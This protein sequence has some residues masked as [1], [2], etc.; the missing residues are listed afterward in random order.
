MKT[1]LCR[2]LLTIVAIVGF[3]FPSEYCFSA[4][5][6]SKMDSAS[7]AEFGAK[8][9]P[10]IDDTLAIQTALNSKRVVSIPENSICEFTNLVIQRNTTLFGAGR[11]S[12]LKHIGDGV[13]IS[14]FDKTT[15]NSEGV[16]AYVD[17]GWFIL[18]D[19]TLRA[20]GT[21]AIDASKNR[22]SFTELT[23]LYVRQTK[24]NPMNSIGFRIDNSPWL[25]NYASYAWKITHCLFRSFDTA[26]KLN[27][28]VN[29]G[30]IENN[31][32]MQNVK[33]ISLSSS[34]QINIAS[35]YVES[36][37]A[38]SRGIIFSSPGGNNISVSSNTFELTN[39]AQNS[40]AYEW[41]QGGI[42]V[43]INAKGNKY[44]LAGD[45]DA[46]IGKKYTGT[47]PA[48]FVED[49]HYL[50]KEHSYQPLRFAPSAAYLQSGAPVRVGGNG[51]GNGKVI[52]GRG[53]S[54]V[55]DHE[56][57][58][59]DNGELI[60]SAATGGF[61]F[62]SNEGKSQ[63]KIDLNNLAVIPVVDNFGTFGNEKFRWHDVFTQ[64][65]KLG[66]SSVLWTSGS[67]DPENRVV[68][69]VGSMYTRT[70]GVP[71]KTLYVKE[72]GGGSKGWVAK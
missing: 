66:S 3:L 51:F 38:G 7:I 41:V 11:S 37:L 44:L 32:F 17:E 49:R 42:W 14:L 23:R 20:N 31:W 62:S 70:D 28:T 27:G 50:S 52:I 8:C 56:I 43:N 39:D 35:N 18:R 55:L 25:P 71:G 16:P 58:Y 34:T 40:Y 69:P 47:I 67:G 53:D 19:F 9:A 57:F 59:G 24:E 21:V 29:F 2:L 45:G 65:I 68:G 26:I 22:T 36:N 30:D 1:C 15:N 33:S 4:D 46:V 12:V 64:E 13:A 72:S 5:S 61:S 48:T 60:F 6:F 63:L 54:N 10:G